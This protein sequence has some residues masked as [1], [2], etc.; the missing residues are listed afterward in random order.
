MRS[1]LSQTT[2]KI[3]DEDI[4]NDNNKICNVNTYNHSSAKELSNPYTH[5]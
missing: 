5:H 4:N 2:P 3:D 1:K